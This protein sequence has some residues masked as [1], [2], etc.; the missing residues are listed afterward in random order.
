MLLGEQWLPVGVLLE[1]GHEGLLQF[2]SELPATQLAV[3]AVAAILPVLVAAA[4]IG[5]A[6]AVA[7]RHSFVAVQLCFAVAVHKLAAVLRAVLS[8]PVALPHEL[9]E[10]GFVLVAKLAQVHPSLWFEHRFHQHC[11]DCSQH[12]VWLSSE[13]FLGLKLRDCLPSQ[14]HNDALRPR[15]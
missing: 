3:H 2:P 5:L 11:P 4:V 12:F 9:V 6:A 14:T 8:A 10:I 13:N 7:M 1:T 15:R